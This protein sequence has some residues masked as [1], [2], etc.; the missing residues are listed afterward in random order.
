MFCKLVFS[1][2][3]SVLLYPFSHDSHTLHYHLCKAQGTDD[4]RRAIGRNARQQRARR[5]RNVLKMAIAI[6][7]GF[8]VCWLPLSIWLILN[9][10]LPDMQ[11]CGFKYFWIVAR[12]MARANCAINHCICF[13]FSGNYRQSFRNLLRRV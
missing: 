9:F 11:P 8:A 13:I 12:C 10:F 5:E 1:N 4:S 2:S 3:C 6:V 7:L